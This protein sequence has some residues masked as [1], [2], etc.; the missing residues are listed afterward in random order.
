M[1]NADQV[2]PG[3]WIGGY[4]SAP[5][6]DVILNMAIELDPWRDGLEILREKR[7][8]VNPHPLLYKSVIRDF[9]A[10]FLL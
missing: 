4:T 8:C 2:Y 3:I 10:A 5:H 9:G 6:F 7:P 1:V